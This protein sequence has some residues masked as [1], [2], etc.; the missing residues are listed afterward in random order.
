MKLKALK[1]DSLSRI[2]VINC[3]DNICLEI[4]ST[5]EDINVLLYYIS[6]IEDVA[7]FVKYCS[8]IELPSDN[9]T[10]LLY[11]KG[12][13]D[14]VNLEYIFEP[15]KVK[16]YTNFK[17]KLPVLATLSKNIGALVMSKTD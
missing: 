5:D 15:F 9:T 14:G 4:E 11:Q 1:L 16:K 6:K 13:L 12:R 8:S 7:D 17:L 2:K 3:P 10:V